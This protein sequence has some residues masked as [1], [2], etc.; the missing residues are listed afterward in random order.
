M[1]GLHRALAGNLLGDA[2][3][4]EESPFL[5]CEHEYDVHALTLELFKTAFPKM[6]QPKAEWDRW[7][8]GGPY[9]FYLKQVADIKGEKSP[10]YNKIKEIARQA[11]DRLCEFGNAERIT[12]CEHIKAQKALAKANIPQVAPAPLIFSKGFR[13]ASA[14]NKTT[15]IIKRS[16]SFTK[17]L[18]L[19]EQ[20]HSTARKAGLQI[21]YLE[22]DKVTKESGYSDARPHK[23]FTKE[24]KD[25]FCQ[26]LDA[27]PNWSQP[28][29]VRFKPE[30][31][32]MVR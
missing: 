5:K 23:V 29:G 20:S 27:D 26:F 3:M 9:D 13:E 8:G 6:K 32:I 21:E 4:R 1:S 22:W 16:R 31:T 12:N 7:D 2:G 19:L 28:K 30:I 17:L 15:F 24:R 14:P 11:V 10:E 25:F 18:E